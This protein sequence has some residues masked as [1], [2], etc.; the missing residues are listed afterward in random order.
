MRLEQVNGIKPFIECVSEQSR[1]TRRLVI[2]ISILFFL[3]VA[4]AAIHNELRYRSNRNRMNELSSLNLEK[5]ELVA[6]A[7]GISPDEL[8]ETQPADD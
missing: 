1:H 6:G 8:S 7:V 4:G 5:I 2:F 3:A